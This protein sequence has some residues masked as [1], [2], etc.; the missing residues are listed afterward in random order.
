MR[1]MFMDDIL[2]Y[3]WDINKITKNYLTHFLESGNPNLKIAVIDSGVDSSHPGLKDNVTFKENFVLNEEKI[4]YTGH[5]TMVCGQ[6]VG[7]GEIKGIVPNC[8]IDV[9]KV[10]NKNN[11]C[12]LSDLVRSLEYV[13]ENDYH[14][15]NLSLGLSTQNKPSKELEKAH[16]IIEKLYKKN[17]VCVNSVGYLEST[18]FHFPSN[19]P[20]TLT[21][22]SLSRE[23]KIVNEKLIANYCVPSGD[24]FDTK[25]DD[26]DDYDEYTTVFFPYQSTIELKEKYPEKHNLPLGYIYSIGES[27]ASAKL[28]GIIAAILSK[29][30]TVNNKIITIDKLLD[31]LRENSININSRLYPN[32]ELILI[33]IEEGKI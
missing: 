32:L 31:I 22:Q 6:I 28:S 16:L 21:S 24:Y 4:D 9:I 29:Y 10:L 8:Q 17:T 3:S 33:K 15:V 14:I 26:Y 20:Y 19:S 25:L 13:Y 5:G 1:R 18:F 12:S 30:L 23:N 7:N 27:L 11:S 2:K